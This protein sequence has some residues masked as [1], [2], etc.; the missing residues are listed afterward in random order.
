MIQVDVK[1]LTEAQEIIAEFRKA[2]YM[3]SLIEVNGKEY[4]FKIVAQKYGA[5]NDYI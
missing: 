5:N 4:N 2:D 3:T 1:D